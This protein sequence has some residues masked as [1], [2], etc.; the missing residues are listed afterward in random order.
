MKKILILMAIT[1]LAAPFLLSGC[2]KSK[3]PAPKLRGAAKFLTQH[4][5]N[6]QMVARYIYTHNTEKIK[7]QNICGG[8]APATF[9]PT[10]LS[11]SKM[12][13]HYYN[14]KAKLSKKQKINLKKNCNAYDTMPIV[15]KAEFT[16][17]H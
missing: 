3:P 2:M 17:K 15:P 13:R 10:Y 12:I 16:F 8:Y 7:I 5:E 1:L 4:Q 9:K 14:I 6:W 11:P